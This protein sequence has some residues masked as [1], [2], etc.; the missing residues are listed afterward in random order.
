VEAYVKYKRKQV[1][2][3]KQAVRDLAKLEG[4]RQTACADQAVTQT[5]RGGPN[6]FRNKP[7][8]DSSPTRDEDDRD[9]VGGRVAPKKRQVLTTGFEHVEPRVKPL[10]LRK[11]IIF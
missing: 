7:P 5:A 3:S 4:D 10:R 8:T 1:S 11:A 6:D 2:H 9:P